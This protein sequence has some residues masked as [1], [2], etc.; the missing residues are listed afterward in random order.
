MNNWRFSAT[1]SAKA[2]IE[3]YGIIAKTGYDNIHL[4]KNHSQCH[5]D[6]VLEQMT[7]AK[8]LG[9]DRQY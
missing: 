2:S 9:L 7:E 1:M 3:I 4:D 6:Y 8:S 5:R